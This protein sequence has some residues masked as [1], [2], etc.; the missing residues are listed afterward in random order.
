MN[1]H[2]L[3]IGQTPNGYSKLDLFFF[4]VPLMEPVK[5]PET[6]R[7]SACVYGQIVVLWVDRLV[8]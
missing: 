3:Y 6:F 4:F 1:P 8:P 2:I 7:L 5:S